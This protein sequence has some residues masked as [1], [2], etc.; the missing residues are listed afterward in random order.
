M[1]ALPAVRLHETTT[2]QSPT[3]G[4]SWP[5]TRIRYGWPPSAFIGRQTARHADSLLSTALRWTF[6]RLGT[7]RDSA[8]SSY[9]DADVEIRA[10]LDAGRRAIMRAPLALAPAI[11]PGRHD[12]IAIRRAGSPW[13][14]VSEIANRLSVLDASPE[15]LANELLIPDE[16]IRWRLFHLAILGEILLSARSLGFQTLSQGPLRPGGGRP[17]FR[18]TARGDLAFD[19]WFEAA[20]IWHDLGVRS[21]YAE[22]TAGIALKDRRLGADLLL[23]HPRGHSFL[24]IECKYSWNVDFVARNG[25]YQ[26]VAYASELASRT[27]GKIM[28]IAVGPEGVVHS[29]GFTQ[30]SVGQIGICPPSAIREV[31]QRFIDIA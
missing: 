11:R 19:L 13:G 27:G 5:E 6:E 9:A 3:S 12:L 15:A 26:A 4:I 7:I 25:Y 14:T 2:T 10:Q 18:L 22:A 28:A 8:V 21:P 20:G 29:S 24:V 17:S 31:L 1:D 16:N 30:L 23:A